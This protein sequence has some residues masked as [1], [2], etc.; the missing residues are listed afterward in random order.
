MKAGDGSMRLTAAR[1]RCP[2]YIQS[3]PEYRRRTPGDLSR[4]LP[5]GRIDRCAKL[6]GKRNGC[7][8]SKGAV[9][10]KLREGVS[11]KESEPGEVVCLA[12]KQIRSFGRERLFT[13]L[14]EPKYLTV[15]RNL[16]VPGLM[17][18]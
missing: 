17:K 13:I 8:D 18:R 10:G 4:K 3:A 7:F 16:M 6:P 1:L 15:G 11:L 5:C 9:G 2:R 14:K 12:I